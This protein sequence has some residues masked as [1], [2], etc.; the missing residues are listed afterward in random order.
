MA[1]PVSGA[2][3]LMRGFSLIR[4]K[5]LRRFV[6]IP[7][8]VNL[9]LFVAAFSWLTYRIKDMVNWVLSY[10]PN[11]LD[12]LEYLIWPLAILSVLVVFSYL[13]S[14]IANWIAAPFNG[15]LAERVELKLTGEPLP[16]TGM[17]DIVKDMPRLFGREWAKLK[18]YLPRAIGFLLLF[19]VPVV[20]QTLG[21]AL[22]FFFTAWMMAIQYL[23]YPFDNHKIP[24]EDMKLALK[25][26]RSASF[27]FGILATLLAMVPILN[28]IVM[29][30]AVCGATAMWVER[31]RPHLLRR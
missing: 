30:V 29:P 31:F 15:L 26:Q 6:L 5:G 7:L 14:A 22:W 1:N 24:F 20:G 28:L 19:L 11:W 13:F 12:W 16:D 8:L 25:Y 2:Q 3:Y 17:L 9:V 4:E 27:S 10:L 23:D 18:Y 21:A